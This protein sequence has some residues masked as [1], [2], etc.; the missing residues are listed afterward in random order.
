MLM[1]SRTIARLLVPLLA[2]TANVKA[3]SDECKAENERIQTNAAVQNATETFNTATSGFIPHTSAVRLLQQDWPDPLPDG[4]V[5]EGSSSTIVCAFDYGPYSSDLNETCVTEGY[6]AV[7]D[8]F[9]VVCQSSG[10]RR[11]ELTYLGYTACFG[12]SC[13][14]DNITDAIEGSLEDD[15]DMAED[16]LGYNCLLLH[17]VKSDSFV[18]TSGL[19]SGVA[20]IFSFLVMMV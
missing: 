9:K 18:I 5:L 8:E 10:G 14:P 3:L 1:L 20:S 13:D 17:D 2:T 16:E 4:C 19:L 12:T 15:I 7:Q 6:Q 11:S